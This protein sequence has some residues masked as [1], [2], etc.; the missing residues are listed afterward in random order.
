MKYIVEA[1]DGTTFKVDRVETA[2]VDPNGHLIL[3][4]INFNVICA[5]FADKWSSVYRDNL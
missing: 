2:V 1:V 4:D 5:V 3:S